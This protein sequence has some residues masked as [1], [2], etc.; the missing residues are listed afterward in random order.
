MPGSPAT[1]AVVM[2]TLNET[3][4]LA[5]TLAHA[6]S[7]GFDEYIVV[8]GGSTDGTAD[9]ARRVA[10]TEAVRVLTVLPGRATQMN[11]GAA[12]ARSDV[13]LFVHAD[14]R[15]PEDARPAIQAAISNPGCVGGRFDV[16]FD[17]DTP[18]SR[19]IAA[20][21]N[22]R[23]R[24]TGMMTGDQA[25]FVRADQF[26]ALGGYAALPL[27]EDVDLSRRLKRRGSLAALR[28]RVTTSYRRWERQGPI[29]TIL[30][31]WSLR[32]LYWLGVS[33]HTLVRYYDIIR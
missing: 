33:P 2:P 27:M 18:L 23:S 16:Q 3:R 11:A 15:L 1:I 10:A 12:T 4:V 30:R 25:I 20:F 26:R 9:L 14:T 31:M 24:L 8:D 17:R 32:F 13:L 28:T 5:D 7:L 22:A 21:M 29:R 6:Q 19:T